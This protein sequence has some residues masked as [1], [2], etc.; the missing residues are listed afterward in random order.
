MDSLSGLIGTLYKSGYALD[1]N[2]TTHKMQLQ[3]YPERFKIDRIYR[4]EGMTDPEDEAILYAISSKDGILKGLLTDGYG[5]YSDDS[6]S[7]MVA[8]LHY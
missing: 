4:F 1:F 7:A 3:E 8:K 5:I 2:N 6:I